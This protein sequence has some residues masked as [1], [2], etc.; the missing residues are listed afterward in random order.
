MNTNRGIAYRAAL[1]LGSAA[2]A[3][4]LWAAPAMAQGAAADADSN[5]IIVTAQR[6]NEKLEDVPMSVAVV[7]QESLANSGINSVRDLQ[8]VTTGFLVNNSG[9]TPQPAIRGI[10]TTNAGAYE[11]NVAL[12]VDGLYQATPQ[13]LNMD[14]PNVQ[15]IQILKGPQG[16]LYGRNATGGAILINTMDP[17]DS[18][19]GTAEATY[20]NFNDYR[21]KAFVAGPLS[22]KIGVSI[23]GTLRHT[24]GYYKRASRTTPGSFDGNFLGLR[25]EAL[26]A[27]LKF[28]LSDTF[29][30]TVAYNYLHA[31]DPRGVVFAYI[32]NVAAPYTGT[33]GNATRPRGLGEAA[34]DVFD[35]NLR[36][37]EGSLKLE[38]DTGIGKLRS[39]T[40]YTVARSRSTF[41]FGGSYVPDS[42][43]DSS[44]RDRTWQENLDFAID[45]IDNLD[46][47]VGGNYY[48]IK[49]DFD[50]V[51][52]TAF[53]GPAA[54]GAAFPDPA[55]ALVPLT[56]YKKLSETYFFRTKEA[57]A[58]FADA[59][60]K[61]TEQLSVNL[62]GRYSKETQSVSGYKI[63]F[64]SVTGAATSCPYSING[65]T[66]AGLTCANGA[67]ARQSHYSKFTPRAS[68]RYEI[69]PGTN[70]YLT[71]SKGFRAGEWNGVIP[72][73]NPSRWFDVKQESVNS[74]ELGFKTV[75][76]R[77]RFELAG[78]YYD[79]R[80]LQVSNTQVIQVGTP[81]V[82]TPLVVLANAPK[83]KIYGAEANIDFK[84]N[85][86]FTVRAGATWLHARYGDEFVI[87]AQGVCLNTAIT[88]PGG[89]ST[90]GF[91][92]NSDPLRTYTN[93]ALDQNLSG[94]QMS[95]APDFT[96]FIGF[97]YLVPMGDGGLRFAANLKYTSSYVVTNP[98]VWGG[99]ERSAVVR[100]GALPD[101]SRALAGSSFASSA[102]EQRN[103]QSAF[104]LLNASVTWTDS[105]DSYYVRVWGNN[106]TDQKYRV[107][108]T[109]N[110]SGTYSPIGEPL[111]FGGTI[112]YKF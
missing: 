23:A 107:H 40:G 76:S 82:A 33:T 58:V 36:M 55:T 90:V 66:V 106:L 11:N 81:P 3:L 79:Y 13:V 67:S 48:N 39:V 74:Y 5:D 94:L 59:T 29:S 38:L 78:F 16:T 80:D 108:Y 72:G 2:M 96:G 109:N 75:T 93:K 41:D 64:S 30:A 17:G 89:V 4:P 50:P 7:T 19:K 49:T 88:C 28:D 18:W 21:G 10:T 92:T 24:D 100:A 46:L 112:G 101:N 68:I 12:F 6:R 62:G 73:D 69:N 31:S 63:N 45:A 44:V 95:R 53:G 105:T 98:A 9:N 14:L 35:V 32:E 22:D 65:E 56:D 1:L 57:W 84:V 102:S 52:N 34:G 85:D 97:D 103:R 20:A 87:N 27:K 15:D 42:Y 71:Y 51:V 60:F 111:S 26:R 25:Q 70:I 83:A 99:D 8:N 91:N 110:G 104:A 47:V 37:N 77:L 43:S 86:N 54:L 61:A